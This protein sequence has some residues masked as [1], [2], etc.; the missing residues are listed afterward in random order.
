MHPDDWPWPPA[1]SR[2]ERGHWQDM[3]TGRQGALP[4]GPNP[5]DVGSMAALTLKLG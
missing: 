5:S 3:D 1:R 4:E 2:C